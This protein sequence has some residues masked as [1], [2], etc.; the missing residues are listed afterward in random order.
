MNLD[1]VI[2]KLEECAHI[3]DDC[4]KYG[5][6]YSR[7][8][9]TILQTCDKM[10]VLGIDWGEALNIPSDFTMCQQYWLTNSAT[11]Y[12]PE[13]DSW[14]IE[15]DNGN[16]GRLQFV[17]ENYWYVVQE[18]WDEFLREMRDNALDYDPM[19]CHIIYDIENGKKAMEGYRDLCKRTQEAMNKKVK[20]EQIRRKQEE[21][22]KLMEGE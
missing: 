5:Y 3:I 7:D 16:V 17:H 8:P 9:L 2:V 15:W 1:E 14:H 13:K 10:K 4:I 22:A 21:L 20:A 11:R 19:N 12:K 6:G 18:E